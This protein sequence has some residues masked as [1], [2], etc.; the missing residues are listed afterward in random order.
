MAA[1][2]VAYVR[3]FAPAP[4]PVAVVTPPP[5]VTPGPPASPGKPGAVPPVK[6]VVPSYTPTGD[7]DVDYDN[8]VKV[9]DNIHGQLRE[10]DASVAAR[11]AAPPTPPPLV[12]PPPT[13]PP[14]PEPPVIVPPPSPAPTALEKPRVAAAPV[15][16]RPLTPE[17]VERG[18]ELFLGHRPLANGGSACIACHTV[19]DGEARE[20]GRLGPELTRSYARLGGRSALGARLWAHETRTM[21]PAYLRHGLE[22]DEVLALVAYLEDAD[23]QVPADTSPVPLKFLLVGLGGAVLALL[24]VS[25][26]WGSRSRRERAAPDAQAAPPPAD[27]VGG[28]L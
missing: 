2:L 5:S 13:A 8:L 21:Q 27:F 3:T 15:S 24:M 7:F 16:D 20:G 22:P 11:N 9:L 28:G 19:N 23:R 10:L 17:D 4:P 1:E 12:V 14:A 6:V 25:A 18:R 26:L